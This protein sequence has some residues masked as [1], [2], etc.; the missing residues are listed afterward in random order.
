MKSKHYLLLFC[1]FFSYEVK[2]TRIAKGKKK[3][4]KPGEADAWNDEEEG[5]NQ[6]W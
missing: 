6:N 3:V 2:L 1:L 5:E 4:S